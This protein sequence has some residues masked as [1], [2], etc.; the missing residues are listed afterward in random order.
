MT[1]KS[2]PAIVADPERAA[3]VFCVQETVV[4][5]DPL[6][7]VGETEIHEPLPEAVQLPPAHPAGSPVIV[8]IC[9]PLFASGLTLVGLIVKLVQAPAD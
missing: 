4:D 6:P 7:L 5:P 3:P 2:L 1:I 9:D 8:T